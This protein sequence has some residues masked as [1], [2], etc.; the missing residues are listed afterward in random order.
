MSTHVFPLCGHQVVRNATFSRRQRKTQ[1]EF[2]HCL[3]LLALKSTYWSV[4]AS[5]WIENSSDRAELLRS[6]PSLE[7]TF[8]CCQTLTTS[9]VPLGKGVGGGGFMFSSIHLAKVP[10]LWV[11][12]APDRG[13]GGRLALTGTIQGADALSHTHFPSP[14]SQFSCLSGTAGIPPCLSFCDAVKKT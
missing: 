6:T 10:H 5:F 3:S 4:L 13:D 9:Q 7:D 12:W 2:N 14:G 8:S 11:L 1:R